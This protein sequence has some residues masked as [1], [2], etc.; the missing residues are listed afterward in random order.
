MKPPPG[1]VDRRAREALRR[2]PDGLG[3]LISAD[4]PGRQS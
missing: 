2:K 1:L 4:E 3:R